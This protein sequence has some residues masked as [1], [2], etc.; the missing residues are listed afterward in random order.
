METILNS[1]RRRYSDAKKAALIEDYKHS[2]LLK[3]QWCE[4]NGIGLSTLHRWLQNDDKLANEHSIQTWMPIIPTAQE[5]PAILPVQI[6]K[7]N[8]PVDKNTDLEL[9][10][11]VMKVLNEL[12]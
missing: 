1:K 4:K 3:K 9:L 6:G 11:M 2:Q 5:K 7:F 8:V 12:C 10:S